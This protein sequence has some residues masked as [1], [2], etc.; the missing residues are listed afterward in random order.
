VANWGENPVLWNQIFARGNARSPKGTAASMGL[1][2][3]SRWFLWFDS[4]GKPERTP[5]AS[6]YR[7]P[8]LPGGGSSAVGL[9]TEAAW[10]KADATY[11]FILLPALKVA[12]PASAVR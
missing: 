3:Y 11:E 9:T 2:C 6:R 7:K 1:V 5:Y 10:K 8:F 12:A 4:A